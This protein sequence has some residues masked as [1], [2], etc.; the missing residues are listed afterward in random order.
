M[1][2]LTEAVYFD[3]GKQFAGAL[4]GASGHFADILEAHSDESGTPDL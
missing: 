4:L 3:L 1:R 2:K